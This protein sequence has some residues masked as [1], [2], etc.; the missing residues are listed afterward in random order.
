MMH[1]TKIAQGL[2]D[3]ARL[4]ASPAAEQHPK[5]MVRPRAFDFLCMIVRY[6]DVPLLRCGDPR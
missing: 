1:H 3:P 6:T 4:P 2:Q 5:T